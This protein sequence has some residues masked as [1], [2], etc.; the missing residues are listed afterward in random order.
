MEII[1]PECDTEYDV[2]EHPES[3]PECGFGPDQ[4]NH[5]VSWRESDQIM[6]LDEGGYVERIYCSKCGAPES[7]F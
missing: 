2:D 6:D 1:C 5:P 4:C 3:C 7:E